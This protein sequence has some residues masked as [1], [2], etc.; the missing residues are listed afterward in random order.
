MTTNVGI[1]HFDR[2]HIISVQRQYLHSHDDKMQVKAIGKLNNGQ[3]SQETSC[4]RLRTKY[5]VTVYL[6][7]TLLIFSSKVDFYYYYLLLY[8][9]NLEVYSSL[10]KVILPWNNYLFSLLSYQTF[11]ITLNM[12]MHVCYLSTSNVLNMLSSEILVTFSRFFVR[13]VTL[14][15][16]ECFT[17]LMSLE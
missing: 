11:A 12:N 9:F 17:K 1:F 15:Y 4:G 3:T 16:S 5:M 13:M 10:T 6:P 2:R 8:L 7:L 14:S